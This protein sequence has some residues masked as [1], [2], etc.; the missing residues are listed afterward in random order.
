MYGIEL[1]EA[2]KRR[3]WTQ[4]DAAS[5]LKVTQAYLSMV[6]RGIRPVSAEL[7]ASA[8][9]VFDMPATALPLPASIALR[10]DEDLFKRELGALGYAGF[11]YLGGKA[12]RNPAELLLSAIDCEDL[13]ARIVEALPWLAAGCAGLGREWL[14]REAKVRD[15]QNRLGYLVELGRQK[16]MQYRGM[17]SASELDTWV[18]TLERSRLVAE[19]TLCRESMTKAERAW[20]REH[21]PSA[22][23]HWNL[24]TDLTAEQIVHDIA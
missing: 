13:D 15:R 20:L 19:D 1:K 14:T 2:R 5:R 22:A 4:S 9:E 12:T 10:L 23:K 8:R 21:R 16:A 3:L 24:L 18:G 7:A 17:A 11:A 6:E